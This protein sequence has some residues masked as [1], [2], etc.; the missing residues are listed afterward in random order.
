MAAAC[1]LAQPSHLLRG[2]GDPCSDHAVVMTVEPK[3][4]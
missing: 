3:V 4:M 2:E 1:L